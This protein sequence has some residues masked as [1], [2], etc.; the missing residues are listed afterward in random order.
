MLRT[1]SDL[2]L[3]TCLSDAEDRNPASRGA[4]KHNS[5]AQVPAAW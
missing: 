4:S 3:W 5:A 1:L 2:E